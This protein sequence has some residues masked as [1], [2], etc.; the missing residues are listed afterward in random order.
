MTLLHQ[1]REAVVRLCAERRVDQERGVVVRPL[2][3][4]EAIGPKADASFV[5][6]KGKERVVEAVFGEARGQAFTD[7][8]SEWSGT[9]KEVFSLDLSSVP[10]RAVFVAAMNAV[11]RSLE[12]A[13]GTIHC[14][15]EDPDRCGPEIARQ[16]AVRFGGKRFGLIGLQP[17][18]LRG[19]AEQFGPEA[20][21]VLDLNPENIGR[22]K[23][24][25]PI[26]NGESD[27]PRLVA[28][29]EV[30]LATGS[31]LVN[32]TIDPIRARFKEADK[33]LVF[34]GNTISGAA[35]LLGLDRLCPYGR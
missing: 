25:V 26:W 24:G 35:A 23:F 15:D 16:L 7:R 12:V 8:P 11:L 1:A 9:L 18:I 30:A 33:P 34:F 14:T 17:A 27:L 19:L 6:K 13:G 2:S 4:D 20:V 3:P 31:S 5:I 28:W 29:C 32:G 21:R 22:R 10:P